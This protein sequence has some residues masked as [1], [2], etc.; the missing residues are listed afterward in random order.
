MKPSRWP[1]ELDKIAWAK[2]AALGEGGQPETL[3]THT[4]YVLQRLSEF[5]RLRPALPDELSLP[6]LW[7]ILY[8]AAFLHDFGKAAAGFQARLH[9]G[10][11]WPHRH[12]VLS[13]A[14][15]DWIAAD[16]TPVEQDWLVA[17]IVSHHKDAG[18]IQRLYPPPDGLTD[19][20]L[21]SR[22]AELDDTMLVALWDWLATCAGDWLNT[23]QLVELGVQSVPVWPRAQAVVS[24]RQQG[25]ARIY[26][27]L[28]IYRRFVK[29]V[30]KSKE[31]GLIVGALTLRGYLMNADHS[32]SAHLGGLPG[33]TFSQEQ[34]LNSRQLEWAD[35]YHHQR[36]AAQTQG[37][38]L[39]T[40]PTGSGKTEAALLWAARQLANRQQTPR[41]FYT[42]PYQASMNAMKLRLNETFGDKMVGLQHGRALLAYYRMLLDDASDDDISP[43]KAVWQAKQAR[44]MADLNYPPIR[45]FSP[46]QMLKGPYRLRGYEKL[47]SDYH[48]ALFILDEIHAYEADRL[49][50]I[51]ATLNYL[52]QNF[53]ARFIVMSATLPQI[54]KAPLREALG[55]TPT[56]EVEAD[57]VLF[58]DDRFQR[59]RLQLLDGDLLDSLA[60][61]TRTAQT[62]RSV[63]V[64]CNLVARA[65]LAFDALRD[66][67]SEAGIE[68]RLLHGRF[69]MRD[70]ST[71]EKIVRERVNAAATGQKPMVLVATQAIEVS[72]DIDFDTIY[73]EPA[74]LEALVQRFGRVNR[75]GRKGTATV[76]V[77]REWD[78]KGQRRVYDEILVEKT[79][80]ILEREN[81]QPINEQKISVWLDEIYRGEIA[82]QWQEKF[83]QARAE[84][85]A[86]CLSSL[87]AF[88]ASRYLEELFYQAFDGTEI[89]PASLQDEYEALKETD[90]I[91]ASELLVP[92]RYGRLH[93][94]RSANRV[95]TD[96]GEWPIVVDVPYDEEMG[97][98][99]S[100]VSKQKRFGLSFS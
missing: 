80:E 51:L 4:W 32:A 84:F 53:Q 57:Q 47:L 85:E 100:D 90:F 16:F 88:E 55:I 97:L 45:V 34:I 29:Q 37:S 38:V 14:F 19:N 20:Q 68:V 98:D 99:F 74:P 1:D 82:D 61:I 25:A 2:S 8:W 78:R 65:Q 33:V 92:I 21:T 58:E 11:K 94:L 6:R 40:A 49:A 62:G 28:K 12:E 5:I 9:G 46:Y 22:V 77:F 10:P 66:E 30:N 75:R 76:S 86:A 63:L 39:L 87:R 50:I 70:R 89:L 44:N 96:K 31:R 56:A 3:A 18:E 41:L 52:R 69:N 54:I 35:L 23:L 26:H 71:L 64:V 17:A 42:L 7:H 48:H 43:K 95:L 15:V 36:Q 93:Q 91:R 27:W 24:V 73:S 67:L 72:L 83:D 81:G 59:H 13:L 60:Q 79:L